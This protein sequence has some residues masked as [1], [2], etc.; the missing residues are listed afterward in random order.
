MLK[1]VIESALRGRG[2]LPGRSSVLMFEEEV[3]SFGSEYVWRSVSKKS[4][5]WRDRSGSRL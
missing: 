5:R 2:A 1:R 4:S 3:S